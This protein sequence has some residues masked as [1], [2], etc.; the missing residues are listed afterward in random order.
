MMEVLRTGLITETR[1]DLDWDVTVLVL[2]HSA[3]SEFQGNRGR[4]GAGRCGFLLPNTERLDTPFLCERE[5]PGPF[6]LSCPR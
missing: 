4:G 6:K 3:I 5:E 2:A 1:L